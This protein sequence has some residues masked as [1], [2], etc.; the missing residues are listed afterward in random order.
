[1]INAFL[2]QVVGRSSEDGHEKFRDAYDLF[3]PCTILVRC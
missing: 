3:A 1:M 2:L